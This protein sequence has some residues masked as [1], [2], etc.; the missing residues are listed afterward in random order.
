MLFIGLCR[1]GRDAEI[2]YTGSNMPVLNMAL[3][4]NYGKEKSTQWL[5]VAMFGQRAETVAPYFK[6]GTAIVAYIENLH[7]ET[8][9]KKDGTTGVRLSGILAQFEFAGGK[10]APTQD[11]ETRQEAPKPA[12]KPT[13]PGG[14]LD[15][16]EDIPFDLPYRGRIAYIV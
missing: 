3:A 11:A 14:I 10:N 6:K 16:N 2:K 1:L 8:Y 5:D 7:V 13:L 12:A 9:E 15:L 4:Y